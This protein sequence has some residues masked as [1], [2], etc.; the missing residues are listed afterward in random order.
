MEQT[1]KEKNTAE[2]ADVIRRQLA[3]RLPLAVISVVG[4]VYLLI[5]VVPRAAGKGGSYALYSL[6][7]AAAWLVLTVKWIAG[8]VLLFRR[9]RAD[10]I[11]EKSRP[12]RIF[13]IVTTVLA[14]L[15][16]A[17]SF[18]VYMI[19]GRNGANLPK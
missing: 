9:Y 12:E 13:G 6:L 1:D 18:A 11:L 10:A 5:T 4:L 8:T 16:A 15:L 14:L 2:R 7:L 3:S 19:A 17:A